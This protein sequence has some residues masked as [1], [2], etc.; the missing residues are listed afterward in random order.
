M[1]NYHNKQFRSVQ[2]SKNGEVGSATVFNY[3]QAGNIVTATYSGGGIINGQLIACVHKDG[4]LEMRYHHIN[5][6]QQLMTGICTSTPK[7]L[8]NG[9]IRLHEKWQWT[10]GDNSSGESIVE[11]I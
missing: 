1:L 4:V 6:Q 3:Q 10:S 5:T 11:E 8:P 9:K 7:I 2:N